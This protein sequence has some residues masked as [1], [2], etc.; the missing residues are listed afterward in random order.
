MKDAKGH[1]SDARGVHSHGIQK[2]GQPEPPTPTIFKK[3]RDGG[4]VF[5]AFPTLPGDDNPAT[6]MAY[7]HVGQH[8]AAHM[9]YVSSAKPAKPAEYA[10][11]LSELKSIGYN[12]KI[13]QKMTQAHY[14][15]RKATLKG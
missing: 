12:P 6:M 8:S 15:A 2:I 10:S 7:A 3:D 1:G 9:N 13:M 14:Q 11:L 5:A 4:G